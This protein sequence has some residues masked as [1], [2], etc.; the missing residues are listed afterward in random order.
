MGLFD[1]IKGRDFAKVQNDILEKLLDIIIEKL[2]ISAGKLGDIKNVDTSSIVK[3]SLIGVT[4]ENS[5]LILG[6]FITISNKFHLELD[7]LI[8]E[9]AKHCVDS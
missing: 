7:N 1:I 4:Q 5:R 2:D 6:E 3:R 9:K 8:T